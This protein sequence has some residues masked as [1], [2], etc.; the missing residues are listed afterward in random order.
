MSKSVSIFCKDSDNLTSKQIIEFIKDGCYFEEEP[1]FS[2]PDENRI[3]IQYDLNLRPI[4]IES[5]ISLEA[6]EEMKHE[7]NEHVLAR[8][9]HSD[10]DYK[11]E[12]KN[13]ILLE[14]IASKVIVLI[15]FSDGELSED[16][17]DMM[18]SVES[19]IAKNNNGLIIAEEGVYNSSL[20]KIL[21]L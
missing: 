7:T 15:E 11:E 18:A 19:F 8:L 5:F 1:K 16:C 3:I 9:E 4:I 17:W 14:I 6:V 13:T 20:Q 12:L 21:I 10:L 2:C